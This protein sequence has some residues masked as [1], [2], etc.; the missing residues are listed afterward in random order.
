MK[1]GILRKMDITN[2]GSATQ[3][4][5]NY[6]LRIENEIIPMN[7][8]LNKPIEIKFL[9]NIYCI[10]CG[11]KTSRSFGQG[12]CYPCFSTAPETEECV[13]RPEL[14]KAHLGEARDLEFAKNHCLIDHFVY[15]A[16]SGGLKVGITRNT[17][18]PT[19]WLDQGASRAII[20]CRTPNRYSAGMVEVELKKSY[21]DKTNWQAMLKGLQDNDLDLRLEKEKALN[22][23]KGKGFSY[24]AEAD[25]VYCIQYPI[26]HYPEKVK[27]FSFDK[28][29]EFKGILNGIKGQYLILDSGR[30]LNIRTHGGF[31]VEIKF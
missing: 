22:F 11:K 2:C 14:C 28:E 21:A 10:R 1:T 29:A 25:I 15:L 18:I 31:Q 26:L 7:S 30:A 9:G 12:Y 20:I 17:Q 5:A 24:Q 6:L 13:L 3:I 27:S 8:M 23:L 4:S 16:W 19:R